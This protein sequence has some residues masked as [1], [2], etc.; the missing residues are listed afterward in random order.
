MRSV[1]PLPRSYIAVEF[2]NAEIAI[3]KLDHALSMHA[4]IGDL[5][6][7]V[8]TIMLLNNRG[9]VIGKFVGL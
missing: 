5:Y 9:Y 1:F 8:T 7:L 3:Y 2:T 6:R 4:A